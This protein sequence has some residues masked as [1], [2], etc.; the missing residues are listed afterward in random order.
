MSSTRKTAEKTAD[1]TRRATEQATASVNDG[2]ER[3]TQGMSQMGSFGQETVEAFMASAS[4]FAKGL[5]K[6]GQENVT[7]AKSQME[8]AAERA[9]GLA[10]VRS[11]QEF[12]EA[13][14]D[15]MRTVVEA[16]IEQTNKV[17]DMMITTARDAAQPLSKRY[18]AMVEMMQPR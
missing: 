12:F 7:F 3:M 2:V 14:A 9:Q 5:E 1:T 13:Q 11:P 6:I 4:T 17:S 16:Q 18:S 10:K 15:L 8:H